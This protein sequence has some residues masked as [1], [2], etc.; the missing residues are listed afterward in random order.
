MLDTLSYQ[1]PSPKVQPAAVTGRFVAHARLSK[2]ERALLAAAIHAG[3]VQLERLTV[4]Q[5][6]RLLGVSSAYIHHALA[7]TPTERREI[8]TGVRSLTDTHPILRIRPKLTL[9]N[10]SETQLWAALEKIAG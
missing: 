10:A 7:A 4:V 2:V 8:K 5:L 1:V 6:A 9:E 3:D